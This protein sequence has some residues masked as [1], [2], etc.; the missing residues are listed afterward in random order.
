MLPNQGKD[1]QDDCSKD[2]HFDECLNKALINHMKKSTKDENGCTVPWI[3]NS[4]NICK[5]R[6]F[7]WSL[8]YIK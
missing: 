2:V 7:L 4:T 6:Q 1:N 5:N 8:F 3:V